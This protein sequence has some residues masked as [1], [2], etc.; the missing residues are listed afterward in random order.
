MTIRGDENNEIGHR[1]TEGTEPRRKSFPMMP[2]LDG[3]RFVWGLDPIKMSALRA[4]C[5][6]QSFN[7]FWRRARSTRVW[8]IVYLA[9]GRAGAH[10][11]GAALPFED[12]DEHDDEE[13]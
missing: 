2:L 6:R 5:L 1:V 13:D 3:V 9:D 7:L 11:C 8:R 4:L 12:E 10:A